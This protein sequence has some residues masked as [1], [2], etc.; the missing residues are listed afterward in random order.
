MAG[1]GVTDPAMRN[2]AASGGGELAPELASYL[3][4][5]RDASYRVTDAHI[6]DLRGAEHGEEALFELTVAAALGAALLRR[7][8]GMRALGGER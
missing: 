1:P 4:L 8:A 5:V 2:S 3:A 7:D 6:E